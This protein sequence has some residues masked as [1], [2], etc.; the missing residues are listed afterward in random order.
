MPRSAFRL[1]R[2]PAITLARPVEAWTALDA[3]PRPAALRHRLSLPRS[4]AGAR[5]EAAGGRACPVA[6]A[7]RRHEPLAGAEPSLAPLGH[8]GDALHRLGIHL[9]G[10]RGAGRD[11]P[12]PARCGDQVPRR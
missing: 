4:A 1:T 8:P 5:A 9:P 11:D 2:D 6:P 7:D 3:A 12:A 10:D